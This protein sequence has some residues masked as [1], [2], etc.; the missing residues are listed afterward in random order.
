MTQKKNRTNPA[1]YILSGIILLLLLGAVIY[2]VFFASKMEM[3]PPGTV[4]NTAGNLNNAGLFCEYNGTV[5]FSN[6]KDG[7]ALYAM[8][9]DESDIRKL[10]SMSVRNILAG[11]SYLYYFQINPSDV[12]GFASVLGNHSLNRSD[13]DGKHSVSLTKDVVTCGQLIDNY[14]YLQTAGSGQPSFYKLKIDK[15]LFYIMFTFDVKYGIIMT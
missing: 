11:G 6:P 10:Y 13:L 14:L 5:Y 8:N 9:P 1:F 7:G 12:S 3:N 15:F 2:Q 4:G